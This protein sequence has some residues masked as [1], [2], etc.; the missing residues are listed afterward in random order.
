[1][2]LILAPSLQ[3][4]TSPW[5]MKYDCDIVLDNVSSEVLASSE[6]LLKCYLFQF[7]HSP[8][9]HCTHSAFAHSTHFYKVVI[10]TLKC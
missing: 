6:K 10:P 9:T 3:I 7:S 4:R 1:M 5:F 2:M 8:F